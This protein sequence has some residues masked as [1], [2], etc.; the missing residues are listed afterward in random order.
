MLILKYVPKSREHG[1]RDENWNSLIDFYGPVELWERYPGPSEL[2]QARLYI[3]TK[4][5][6][7]LSSVPMSRE[8]AYE[9]FNSCYKL[10]R[11]LPEDHPLNH[12]LSPH[13]PP[14]PVEEP[15][16]RFL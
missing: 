7:Y 16:I 8:E 3:D 10:I 13:S 15:I 6:A 12:F 14:P 5:D 2:Y 9:S 11:N 1:Q 4:D